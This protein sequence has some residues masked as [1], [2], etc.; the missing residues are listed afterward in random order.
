MKNIRTYLLLALLPVLIG[1]TGCVRCETCTTLNE[2]GELIYEE[3][4]CGKKNIREQ[5]RKNC[6]NLANAHGGTCGCV[7]GRMDEE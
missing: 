5:G 1:I 6:E 7:K 4:F 3:E 2:K